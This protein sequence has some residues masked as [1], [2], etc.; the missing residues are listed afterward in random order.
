MGWFGDGWR[1]MGGGI[2]K[3]GMVIVVVVVVDWISKRGMVI[4]VQNPGD[5]AN[6]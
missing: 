1:V 3:R 4:V 6:P 5:F 2:S